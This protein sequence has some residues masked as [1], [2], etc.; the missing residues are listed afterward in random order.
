MA[1]FLGGINGTSS[2]NKLTALNKKNQSNVNKAVELYVKFN[3]Q[4]EFRDEERQKGNEGLSRR[5]DRMAMNT[6]D[7][8]ISYMYKLPERERRRV[9]KF[10][11]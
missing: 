11:D 7:E 5:Y 6:L 8:H 9:S 2:S 10:I 3:K 1:T 4:K